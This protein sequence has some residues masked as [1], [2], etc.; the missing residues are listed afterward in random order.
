MLLVTPQHPLLLYIL[1]SRSSPFPLFRCNWQVYLFR[2]ATRSARAFTPQ[3][4]P[5]SVVGVISTKKKKRK[6]KKKEK[7]ASML[8]CHPFL[9][10]N[11]TLISLSLSLFF[12]HSSLLFF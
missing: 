11:P 6:G 2:P 4:T 1:A 10:S 12:F 9:K 5:M 3:G 7:A 8:V